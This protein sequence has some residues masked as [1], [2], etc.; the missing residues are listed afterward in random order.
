MV[1]FEPCVSVGDLVTWN[2]DIKKNMKTRAEFG[3][4]LET[5][6]QRTDWYQEKEQAHL[7]DYYSATALILW[8]GEQETNTGHNCLDVL[9]RPDSG[10]QALT[11]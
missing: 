6:W 7:N 9:C 4:V 11:A 5:Y 3:L 10:D 2:E 1:H 8:D